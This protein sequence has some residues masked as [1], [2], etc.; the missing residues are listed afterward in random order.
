MKK[1]SGINCPMQSP[2]DPKKCNAMETCK[3]YTPVLDTSGMDAVVDLTI[4]AFGLKEE[5]KQKLQIMFQAYVVEYTKL[6]CIDNCMSMKL[7][8]GDEQS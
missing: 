2:F 7:D 8:F 1:C 5:D 4:K 6:M 3:N